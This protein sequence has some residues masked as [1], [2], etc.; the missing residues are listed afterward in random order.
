MTLNLL[1]V[2]LTSIFTAH[3]AMGCSQSR[4]QVGAQYSFQGLIK[5][6]PKAGGGRF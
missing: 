4:W 2:P 3:S 5:M 6:H 1:L